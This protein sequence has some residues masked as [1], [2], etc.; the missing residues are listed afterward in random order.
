MRIA[1][2][3]NMLWVVSQ[4][5]MEAHALAFAVAQQDRDNSHI[6]QRFDLTISRLHLLGQGPQARYLDEIGHLQTVNDMATALLEL[7]PQV[8]GHGK[9]QH[10][11]L[12]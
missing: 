2:T 7:D 6:E 11:A 4:T 8:L 9:Q 1:V 12:F 5:Q 3:Q 10:Q